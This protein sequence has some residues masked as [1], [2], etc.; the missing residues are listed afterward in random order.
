[1]S[2]KCNAHI[3]IL[4]VVVVFYPLNQNQHL[5]VFFGPFATH[6]RRSVKRFQKL[7]VFVFVFVLKN[8]KKKNNDKET[9]QEKTTNSTPLGPQVQ[10]DAR[11]RDSWS[12]GRER[13]TMNTKGSMLKQI[14]NGFES[15]QIE[16]KMMNPIEFQCS[17]YRLRACR[18]H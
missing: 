14:H 18:C 5:H 11:F 1:V 16:E 2:A 9:N 7:F 10:W 6:R 8:T 3:L 12:P 17:I 4:V 13:V 15:I